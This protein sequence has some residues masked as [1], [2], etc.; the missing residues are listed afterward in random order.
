ML[1]A[2]CSFAM[3]R[4]DAGDRFRWFP[5]ATTSGR[6]ASPSIHWAF[7][8]MPCRAGSITW[9]P[10]ARICPSVWRRNPTRKE[11]AIAEGGSFG[12]DPGQPPSDIPLALRTGAVLLRSAA[13][14]TKGSEALTIT[15]VAN[16]LEWLAEKNAASYD[17][18]VDS[19]I[20]AEIC[21]I[22]NR[23]PDLTLASRTDDFPFASTASG[24]DF[25]RGMSCSRALPPKC[26][27]AMEP[28]PMWK[29][30]CRRLRPWASMSCIFRPSVRSGRPFARDR[31]TA[32]SRSP[33]MRAAHGRWVRA[34]ADTR[35]STETLGTLA[36]FEQPG[37]RRARA[38][39]RDCA[40]HRLPVLARIILG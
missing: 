15:E 20:N 7:G 19:P 21:D 6:P 38:C 24:R 16:S 37:R 31:I 34:K 33:A 14:R 27:D 36:D 12:A 8:S 30:V 39:A 32:S 18:S 40:R 10:G 22:A 25:R 28:S 2:V 11:D 1:Q 29:P 13:G 3:R 4:N 5:K 23:Y 26:R 35:V 17:L 9:A